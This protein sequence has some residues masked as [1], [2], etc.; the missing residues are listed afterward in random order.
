MRIN[1]GLHTFPC[2][3]GRAP[4]FWRLDGSVHDTAVM[5]S[6]FYYFAQRLFK[7]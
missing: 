4:Y 1:Q 3:K 6:N 7:E 5:S 2:G